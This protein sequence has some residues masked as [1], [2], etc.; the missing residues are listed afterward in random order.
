MKELGEVF[1]WY[2]GDQRLIKLE[3]IIRNHLVKQFSAGFAYLEMYLGI[4]YCYM[5]EWK[6]PH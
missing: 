2:V 6:G 4:F 5:T 1:Y 3:E